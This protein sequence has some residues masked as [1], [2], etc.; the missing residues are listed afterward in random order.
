MILNVCFSPQPVH[1]W[2][3]GTHTVHLMENPS[4]HHHLE[5]RKQLDFQ[6]GF[7]LENDTFHR[8]YQAL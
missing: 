4:R 7:D 8:P 2:T 6:H 1:S 5:Q 3:Y